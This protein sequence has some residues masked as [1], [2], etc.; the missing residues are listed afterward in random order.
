[1]DNR[2]TFVGLRWRETQ[3]SRYFRTYIIGLETSNDFSYSWVKRT[4]AIEG[5]WNFTLPNFWRVNTDVG[6]VT[7]AFSDRLTRGGPVMATPARWGGSFEVQNRSG[8]RYGFGLEAGSERSEDGSW[9]TNVELDLGARVGD[10]L[11][12]SFNPELA[13]VRSM[14]QYVA[15]VPA[16]SNATYDN[17]YVFSA[18][19]QSEISAQ[20]R[21]NYT[22]TPN[23]TLET[24]A[25]PFVSS[26]RFHTFGELVAPRSSRLR[27]YG[28]DP[29]DF[30]SI[31]RNPDGSYTVTDYTESFVIENEDFNVRSFRSNAV[32]RW[33]WRPG[34]TLFLVWQQDREADKRRGTARAEDLFDTLGAPGNNFLAIKLTY[35]TSLR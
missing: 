5:M 17:R 28:A 13:R 3:P 23:L 15:T 10:R 29:A 35:W 19:D 6:Y 12:L 27:V 14:R 11:D 16:A 9:Q 33:E 7:R 25:E 26:G 4:S 2:H 24:Y 20:L 8:S 30:T 22:F 1:V 31:D 21:A 34:S 18:V 32:L